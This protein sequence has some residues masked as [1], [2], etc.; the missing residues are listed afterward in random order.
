MFARK[1]AR[2]GCPLLTAL[3]LAIAAGWLTIQTPA[4]SPR[5]SK[6][7]GDPGDTEKRT[8]RGWDGDRD[9]PPPIASDKTVKY[10]YPIVYVRVPRPY[11]KAYYGINHLNQAGLHQTNAPGAEL[12]LLHPDGR[13]ES[14][15][16]VEPQESITDPMVSFDGQSVYFAKLHHMATGPTASMTNLQSR[17]GADIYKVRVPTRK[18]VRLTDQQRTPNT[19]AVLPGTE[20]HPRGVHNLAP[21][22]VAGGKVVFVSDRN[23]Y[24]GVREQTQ[25]ALQLFVMDDDGS[26]VEQIGHLNLGTALHPVALTDGRVMFSSL[27]TQGQTDCLGEGSPGQHDPHRADVCCRPTGDEVNPEH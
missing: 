15:V 18:V 14:L 10:D 27:E 21:C 12:R 7:G 9:S 6:S 19:G 24:L 17:E 25:P 5:Q 11:P 16:S 20:S 3:A 2:A 13:D 4:E 1:S 26:N 22:P 23:D 8:R